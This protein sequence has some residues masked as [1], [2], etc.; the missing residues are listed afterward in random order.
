[1]K[2]ISIFTYFSPVLHF[3]HK[4]VTWFALQ[5]KLLVSI[6][7]ATLV[8]NLLALLTSSFKVTKADYKKTSFVPS[9]TFHSR[10]PLLLKCIKNYTN[11]AYQNRKK[12]YALTLFWMEGWGP[13]RL[14]NRFFPCNFYK[15]RGWP[16]KSFDL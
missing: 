4:P 5:I 10:K 7:N 11:Q 15:R 1:M 14:P 9:F 12:I 16:P 6:W 8:W 3:I 2:T 13:K